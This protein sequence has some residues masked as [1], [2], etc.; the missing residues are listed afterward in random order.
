MKISQPSPQDTRK[1]SGRRT[2][3]SVRAPQRHARSAPSPGRVQASR[4]GGPSPPRGV[5]G[6]GGG[7]LP[8]RLER[9]AGG[10]VPHDEELEHRNRFK[11]KTS[12]LEET[13]EV[14]PFD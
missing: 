7:A 8:A 10:A 3:R 9:A 5:L 14:P 6:R 13:L 4:S 12:R 11:E 2:T 1:S